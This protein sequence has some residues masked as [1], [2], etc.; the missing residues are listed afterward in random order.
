[1]DMILCLNE[2]LFFFNA[3]QIGKVETIL[4]VDHWKREATTTGFSGSSA[5]FAPD[6]QQLFAGTDASA[7]NDAK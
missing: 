3:S 2:F 1:M 7:A 4:V 5:T 6:E